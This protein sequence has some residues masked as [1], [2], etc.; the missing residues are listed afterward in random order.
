MKESNRPQ[1]CDQR[2]HFQFLFGS[3]LKQPHQLIKGLSL[4]NCRNMT[5]FAF[6]I[7]TLF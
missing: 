6:E 2:K 5:L 4:S 3:I 7:E 1:A